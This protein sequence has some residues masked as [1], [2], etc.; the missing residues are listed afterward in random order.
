[1]M[2]QTFIG[3]LVALAVLAFSS[4]SFAYDGIVVGTIATVEVGPSGNF[5]V[6]LT[7][8][9]NL[10]TAGADKTEGIVAA[11]A[12]G[13]TPD[14]QKALLSAATAAYLSGKKVRLYAYNNGASGAGCG[15]AVID[16]LP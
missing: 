10:C 1:M 11:G 2:K 5:N 12:L 13:V 16:L 7:G 9:P 4:P 15:I 3:S 8:N 6:W 14:G